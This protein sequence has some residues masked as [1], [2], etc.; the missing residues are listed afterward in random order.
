MNSKDG[1]VLSKAD[2]SF[3]AKNSKMTSSNEVSPKRK[4]FQKK[5][6]LEKE[7]RLATDGEYRVVNRV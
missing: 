5:R 4:A 3:L 2:F 7:D 6:K 1:I